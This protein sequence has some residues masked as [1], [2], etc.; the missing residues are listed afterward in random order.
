MTV[1]DTAYISRLN[2]RWSTPSCFH[3]T[4]RWIQLHLSMTV[5]DTAHPSSHT[6]TGEYSYTRQW[7]SMMQPKCH[8]THR[9]KYCYTCQWLSMMQP[10]HHH[11]LTKVSTATPVHDCQWQCSTITLYK[12]WSTPSSTC[13][14][15][16]RWVQPHLSV[17]SQARAV[18]QQVIYTFL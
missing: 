3:H 14:H 9:G 16:H 1:S 2:S 8:H 10:T 13:H 18:V 4:H 17:T 5:G 15:T 6:H 12:R 7:L 11:T